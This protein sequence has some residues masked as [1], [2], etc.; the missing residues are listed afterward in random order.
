[1]ESLSFFHADVKNLY[2]RAKKLTSAS[3]SLV[4]LFAE[5]ASR[6]NR[7]DEASRLRTLYFSIRRELDWVKSGEVA[8]SC[9]HSQANLMASLGGL[10]VGGIIKMA[11]RNEQLSTFAD[12]LLKSPTE[13]ERPFGL[14]MVCI[15]PKGLP[16]NAEAI[17]ISELARETNRPQSEIINKLQEHGYLLF[18]E[19]TFSLLIDRLI[20]DVRE[21]R[22][23]LPV[24]RETLSEIMASGEL[25]PEDRNLK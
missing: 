7:W 20:D 12:Y 2:H 11:S 6:L 8:A 1:M 14:V 13:K 21:G 5:E 16:D 23:R 25:K 3:L 17:S 22:L 15:G 18:D 9:G 10:V 19:K 4:A 24:S